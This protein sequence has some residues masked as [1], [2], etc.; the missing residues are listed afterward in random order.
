MKSTFKQRITD[1]IESKGLS[2]SAF[3][4]SID[5]GASGLSGVL[6]RG[7]TPGADV[8]AKIEEEIG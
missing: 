5:K 7:S 3:S 8:I 2:K 6:S 1:L 4:K